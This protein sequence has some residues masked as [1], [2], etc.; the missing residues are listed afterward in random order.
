MI[1]YAAD[2]ARKFHQ[3][4]VGTEHILLGLLRDETLLSSKLL[5]NLNVNLSSVRQLVLKKLGILE[6]RS[7]GKK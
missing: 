2:E 5:E 1:Q 3:T 6:P 4:V 7:N